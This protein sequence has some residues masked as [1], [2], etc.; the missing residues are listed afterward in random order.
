M[1]GAVRIESDGRGFG[2]FSLGAAG[3]EHASLGNDGHQ[4]HHTAGNVDWGI[5]LFSPYRAFIRGPYLMRRKGFLPCE[6]YFY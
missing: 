1:A 6:R 2:R 4:L 3:K 5:D